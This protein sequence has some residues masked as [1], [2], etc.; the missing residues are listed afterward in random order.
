MKMN[1]ERGTETGAP[2]LEGLLY[3]EVE[4][5]PELEAEFHAWY[6][7][8]HIPERLRIPGFVSGNRYAAVEGRPRW[9][10]A[11]RLASPAALESSEYRQWMG[12]L[13]TPWTKRMVSSTAVRRSVFRQVHGVGQGKGTSGANGLLA[14]RYAPAGAENQRLHDWHDQV[15]ACDLARLTGVVEASRYEDTETSEQL[16]LYHLADPWVPQQE[17]F[18]RVW[19]AGWERKRDSLTGWQRTL[20]VRIL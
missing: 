13:Q 11:Y 10:A 5:P 16:A 3:V 8:E 17:A 2:T 15:F 12:P 1:P 14:V 7:L 20:Y 9:L 6:N 19:T 18:A 4:C